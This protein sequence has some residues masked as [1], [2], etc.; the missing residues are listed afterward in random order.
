MHL[1]PIS[2]ILLAV[3]VTFSERDD[4]Q[5]DARLDGDW[6]TFNHTLEDSISS[7][8][9]RGATGV[10]PSTYWIDVADDGARRAAA[11]GDERPFTWG[12]IT[13]LRVRSGRV[14]A[15]LDIDDPT[16]DDEAIPLDE[17]LHLLSAW[18]VRVL[19]SASSEQFSE[20]YRRNPML[21]D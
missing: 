1:A 19:A 21:T 4:G 20:T 10:G 17:F 18:H 9:P 5:V 16:D 12:N 13:Q 7:L 15:S 3:D 14:F 2:G 6:P 8:P 11:A